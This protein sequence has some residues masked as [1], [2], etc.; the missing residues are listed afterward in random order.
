MIAKQGV[1]GE[2]L[3]YMTEMP[4]PKMDTKAKKEDGIF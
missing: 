3:G 2:N 4:M 1:K